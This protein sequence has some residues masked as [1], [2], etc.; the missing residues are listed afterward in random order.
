MPRRRAPPAL[1]ASAPPE[2]DPARDLYGSLLFQA[3]RFRRV[4]GY[5]ALHWNGCSARIEA[6]DETWFGGFQP[7]TL[8]LGDPG[9]RDAAIH[10]IQACLPHCEVLPTSVERI[11]LL[12]PVT[13]GE[14]RL[15]ARERGRGELSYLYD[16]WLTDAEG[17]LLEA[18]HGLTLRAVAGATPPQ[19]WAPALLA[20]RLEE[21]ANTALPGLALRA[22]VVTGDGRPASERAFA[23]AQGE[24]APLRHRGDGKPLLEAA[25]FASASH[26]HGLTLALVA[27]APVACDL[28]LAT[29]RSASDWADLLGPDR[30]AVAKGLADL[31]R[32]PL[33]H[34]ATRVWGVAESLRKVG[35]ARETPI[36]FESSSEDTRS[37]LG[38]SFHGVLL[39]RHAARHGRAVDRDG[40]G[41]DGRCA[42]MRCVMSSASRRPTSSATST[43]R[44]TCAGRAAVASSSC[45]STRPT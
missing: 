13:G 29:G 30:F 41:G 40:A 6:R 23:I 26:A 37:P 39:A 34:A 28:E 16:F 10:A 5:D 42:A 27:A 38:G 43:T 45:A 1:A 3:G 17:A 7:E 15:L 12:R 14:V 32:E 22:A 31:L 33:D 25:P 8:D 36:L 21:I 24:W 19:A 4:R 35:A 44:I 11:D 2:L 9:A 18:W 20:P